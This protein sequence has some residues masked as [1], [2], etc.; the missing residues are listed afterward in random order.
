MAINQA[1]PVFDGVVPSWA[2]I[3]VR[4]SPVRAPL[5]EMADIKSI[6]TACSM[7]IGEQRGASGGR[8][9]K[10]STGATK[11]EA[12][13]T[14]YYDGF[15]RFLRGLAA[16]APPGRGNQRAL[17]LVHFGLQIQFTP[18][19]STEVFET[20][21]KGCRYTGRTSAPAEGTDVHTIDVNLNPLEIVDMIDGVEMALL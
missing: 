19:G 13:L 17:S 9:M 5:I 11:Y 16:A 15:L 20:R 1:F 6:S 4:A 8:V 2:D 7:D 18:L 14:L 3:I 12:S 21:I 10:R